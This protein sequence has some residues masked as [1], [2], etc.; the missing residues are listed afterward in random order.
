MTNK[1]L[2]TY[3]TKKSDVSEVSPLRSD[4]TLYSSS[5][6]KIPPDIINKQFTSVFTADFHHTAMP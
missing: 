6:T 3:I 1:K 4:G 5:A 2:Y